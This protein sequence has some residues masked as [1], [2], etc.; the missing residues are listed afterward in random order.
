MSF[1]LF[2]KI[3]VNGPQAHPLFTWLKRAKRGLLGSTAI[4]WNFTKF[5]VSRRGEVL[6]RF[7]PM[8]R[9]ERLARH[10]ESALQDTDQIAR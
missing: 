7:A 10:I 4:K 9:P 6:K 1:P 8:D 3:A 2:R 5:L